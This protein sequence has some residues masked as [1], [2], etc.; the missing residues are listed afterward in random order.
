MLESKLTWWKRL[1]CIKLVV[2]EKGMNPSTE[3]GDSKSSML[4]ISRVFHCH[5][6]VDAARRA[7]RLRAESPA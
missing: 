5:C 6:A 2:N 1:I 4:R 3:R 7:V